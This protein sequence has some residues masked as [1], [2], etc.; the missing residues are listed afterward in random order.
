MEK[1]PTVPIQGK[2]RKVPIVYP[3][4]QDEVNPLVDKLVNYSKCEGNTGIQ[5]YKN[6]QKGTVMLTRDISLLSESITMTS[7]SHSN[8]HK[9]ESRQTECGI[10][11]PERVW[12]I[13]IHGRKK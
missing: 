3:G 11:R 13:Q 10:P 9:T 4:E 5:Y 7:P 12:Y 2:M 8:K 6:E 1:N